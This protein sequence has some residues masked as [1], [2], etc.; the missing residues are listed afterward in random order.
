MSANIVVTVISIVVSTIAA[1]TTSGT[2]SPIQKETGHSFADKLN[3]GGGSVGSLIGNGAN[4]VGGQ[5]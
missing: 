4:A 2:N 3:Q 5:N 1:A